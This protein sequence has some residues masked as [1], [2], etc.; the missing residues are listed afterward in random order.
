MLDKMATVREAAL[1]RLR[2]PPRIPLSQWVEKYMRLP[3][4]LAAKSG[5]VRLWPFQNGIADAITD[6]EIERV[7]VLKSAR[8]GYSMLMTSAIANYVA[9]EPAPILL[10]LPTESDCRDY[11]VSD[12]DP[13]FDASPV[14]AGI[15]ADGADESGRNT[16]THRRFPGGFLK[17]V[18]TKAPRNLRRHTVRILFID[19]EDGMDVTAEGD[20]VDLAIKRTT[21]FPNRKIV[22]GSTPTDNETSSILAAYEA[23]DKRVYDVKCHECGEYTEI[24][25]KDIQWDKER[26]DKG[27]VVRHLPETA[28]WMCPCCGCKVEHRHKPEMVANGRWRATRPEVQGH[29][30]FYLNALISPAPNASWA[31]LAKEFLAA[32]GKPEKMQ[33]FYNTILGLP[34][35]DGVESV[36]LDAVA[37]RGEA[38]GLNVTTDDGVRLAIPEDVLLMTAGVDVQDDRVEANIYG[39]NEGG[40]AY[41]LGHFVIYGSPED[42]TTW[43]DLDELLLTKWEH[44][45]GGKIGI[46]ATCVDSGDG[47]W[48]DEVY[49]YCWPRKHRG[50]MAIKGM[51]GGRPWIVLSKGKVARGKVGAKGDLWIVG[52]DSIK[53][54][55]FHRLIRNPDSVRF[56]STLPQVWYEQLTSE[57]RVVKILHGRPYKRFERISGRAAEALDATV[58]AWAARATLQH[59]DFEQR[60]ERLSQP[61]KAPQSRMTRLA[62]LAQRLNG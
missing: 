58:Y 46:E 54:T 13:Y 23:S 24:F 9:N 11:V 61:D 28:H 36:D 57:R 8:V 20:P 39:W 7:S 42:D 45:L 53:S 17:V 15:L 34:W 25:W 14:V 50:V 30:G 52:V 59:V 33:I 44:P 16:L 40:V 60:R 10:A 35:S 4:G 6:P 29:A 2:P 49:A 12:L 19:E 1:R 55:L 37:G 3:E 47:D 62:S 43:R 38:I 18:P 31:N 21:T 41:A 26:D 51:W 56:S 48:T 27:N 32:H 22:R 5:S